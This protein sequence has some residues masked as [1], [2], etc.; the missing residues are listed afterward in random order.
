MDQLVFFCVEIS[1]FLL[2]SMNVL[3]VLLKRYRFLR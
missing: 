2:S 3:S 1:L